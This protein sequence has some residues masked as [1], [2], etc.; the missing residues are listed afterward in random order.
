MSFVS[1]TS[2]GDKVDDDQ[3]EEP[4]AARWPRPPPT[5]TG[6]NCSLWWPTSSQ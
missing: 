6:L 5:D 2:V 4:K 3:Q 1:L